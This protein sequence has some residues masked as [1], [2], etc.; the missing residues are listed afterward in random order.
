AQELAKQTDDAALAETFAPVAEALADNIETISQE[1]V[2]A[3]GHPVDIGGYYRPDAAKV[4][5]VMRPSKTF[6]SVI[7]SLA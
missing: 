4:A 3:Q 7:D 6:N 5:T 2:D 1:L